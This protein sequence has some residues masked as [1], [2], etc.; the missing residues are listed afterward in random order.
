M[1]LRRFS[2]TDEQIDRAR[3]LAFQEQLLYQPFIVSDDLEVGMGMEMISERRGMVSTSVI[4]D[5]LV[6]SP[7]VA[8]WRIAPEDKQVFS[9]DNQCVRQLYENML[10]FI[11]DKL[12]GVSGHSFA[13]V[14][15]CSGYF[16]INLSL[17]GAQDAVGYDRLDYAGAFGLLNELTGSTARFINRGY[18]S[19]G[20]EGA[21]QVDVALS[22]AVLV[23]LAD[24]L[25]H[26]AFLGSLARKAIFIWTN[27]MGAM[28]TENETD[29]IL[30]YNKPNEYFYAGKFPHCFNHVY[31]TPALLRLSLEKIGF[32][33]IHEFDLR[34][35]GMSRERF[36]QHRGYLAVRK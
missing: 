20:I 8:K 1:D 36:R 15:C 35:E 21:E 32:S 26:L 11:E 10:T 9:R 6:G 13:E 33:E 30:R 12:G 31:I 3:R 16:P 19:G 2:P 7:A 4:P 27:T 28:D 14:G 22:V 17:R 24:P 5:D 25:H 23:H 34:P 29:L 18:R